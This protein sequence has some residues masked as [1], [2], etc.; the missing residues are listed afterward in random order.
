MR[1]IDQKIMA[2]VEERDDCDL[3]RVTVMGKEKN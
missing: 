2:D 3:I 1:Q